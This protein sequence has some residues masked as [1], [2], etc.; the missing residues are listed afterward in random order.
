VLT[1]RPLDP[2]EAA[3]RRT[4]EAVNRFVRESHE[5]LR[6]HPV[7]RE[8][9][10][11]GLPPANGVLT[12]GAGMVREI[13]SL[14]HHL[15]LTAAVI[16]GERTVVGLA[17]LL[18]YTSLCEGRFT[19]MPDTDLAEKVAAARMALQTHDLVYLHIKG[20]D[21]CAHDRDPA[22]KRAFLERIDA[23]L[24]PLLTDPLV[25]GVSADHST[26]CNTGRHCGDPVPSLLCAPNG[27]KDDCTRYGERECMSGG[28][29]RLS[30]YAFLTSMLD[31]MGATRNYRSEDAAFFR[32]EPLSWMTPSSRPP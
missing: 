31:A 20:T 32:A 22:A 9:A 5:R 14:V 17:Q 6:D 19:A 16:T 15:G 28:L 1:S 21:I 11:E 8:R 7:N 13:R 12:R 23:A 27:R 24:A 10:A 18:G 30:G 3:A 25:I 29:G 26:D 4:A 2:Q